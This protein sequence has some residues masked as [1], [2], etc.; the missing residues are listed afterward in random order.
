[1]NTRSISRRHFFGGFWG[2]VLGILASH[3]LAPVMLPFGCF[4]GVVLGFWYQELGTVIV[5]E[6]RKYLIARRDVVVVV[7]PAMHPIDM[8]NSIKA[9]GIT[10]GAIV[11][12]IGAL[13]A[14]LMS[15]LRGETFFGALLFGFMS[16]AIGWTF[17][18]QEMSFDEDQTDRYHLAGYYKLLELYT[19]RGGIY[20]FARE[21]VLALLAP[22]SVGTALVI[23]FGVG[24]FGL[25]YAV[26]PIWVVVSLFLV[27][28]RQIYKIAIG[29]GHWLCVGVTIV[30][31]GVT[32]YLMNDSMPD[33]SVWLTALVAGMLS[34]SVSVYAHRGLSWILD[35]T[36][37]ATRFMAKTVGQHWSDIR[38]VC[39]RTFLWTFAPSRYQYRMRPAVL[40]RS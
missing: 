26:A 10:C 25:V 37:R 7:Q 5:N 24:C 40:R 39:Y 31:T 1:M 35:K 11:F 38:D 12:S 9:L 29:P 28:T 18:Y 21:F 36:P 22:F 33:T 8:A 4:A 27:T 17:I 6:W 19:N 34:G 14:L 16:C 15:G 30:V 3:F 13:C 23:G 2:G 32:A 20:V